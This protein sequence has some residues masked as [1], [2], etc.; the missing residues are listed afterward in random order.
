M[1]QTYWLAVKGL[2]ELNYRRNQKPVL[3]ASMDMQMYP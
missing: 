1:Q 3:L 2:A